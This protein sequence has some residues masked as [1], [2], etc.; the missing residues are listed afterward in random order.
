MIFKLDF[1]QI[2]TD[3]FICRICIC[4]KSVVGIRKYPCALHQEEFRSQKVCLIL[5][6]HRMGNSFCVSKNALIG[7]CTDGSSHFFQF[8][9]IK[10]KTWG[11]CVDVSWDNPTTYSASAYLEKNNDR[12][13]DKLLSTERRDYI[14]LYLGKSLKTTRHEVLI[15]LIRHSVFMR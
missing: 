3:S 13:E 12:F 9:V 5:S 6:G 4:K 11:W 10:P 14:Q 7:G 1:T 8:L 15:Q 2:E